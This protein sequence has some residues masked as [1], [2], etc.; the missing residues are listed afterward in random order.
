[1]TPRDCDVSSVV[2]AA[3]K[4]SGEGSGDAEVKVT[5]SGGRV[6]SIENKVVTWDL[7]GVMPGTYTITAVVQDREG[8]W[9]ETKTEAVTVDECS[10]C[11]FE[12]SCPVISIIGPDQ[13]VAGQEFKLNADIKGRVEGSGFYWNVSAGMIVSGQGTQKI[14]IQTG[15]ND[16]EKIIAGFDLQG[17]GGPPFCETRT[18]FTVNLSHPKLFDE[19]IMG[20]SGDFRARLDSFLADIG[21]FPDSSGGIHIFPKNAADYKRIANLINQHLELRRIKQPIKIVDSGPSESNRSR[22]ELWRMPSRAKPNP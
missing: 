18:S 19:F 10:A 22:L 17:F 3:I 9:S 2:T 5:V 14:T 11:G 6:R 7:V 21:D 1:M 16:P 8:N 12:D 13:V 4:F 20:T 15:T